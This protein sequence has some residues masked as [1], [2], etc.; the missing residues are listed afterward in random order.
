MPLFPTAGTYLDRPARSPEAY[1]PVA[2]KISRIF[3]AQFLIQQSLYSNGKIVPSRHDYGRAVRDP[4]LYCV[5]CCRDCMVASCPART[6]CTLSAA[7]LHRGGRL[8][9]SR[10]SASGPAAS[11]TSSRQPSG[12]MPSSHSSRPRCLSSPCWEGCT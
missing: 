5:P 8:A 7:A 1:E 10:S 9:S 3:F 12:S 6:R 2:Y 11:S 4:R